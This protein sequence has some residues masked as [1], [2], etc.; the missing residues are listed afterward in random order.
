MQAVYRPTLW[1]K[2]ASYAIGGGVIALALL[3]AV[4]GLNLSD[5][6]QLVERFF[7]WGFALLYSLFIVGTGIALSHLKPNKHCNFWNEFGHQMGNSIATLAL[8]FTLLGISLGVGGL[9]E[10]PLSPENAPDIIAN[11]TGQFSLAFLTTVVGLPT[12]TA[13]RAVVSLR[14]QHIQEKM[15]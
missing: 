12:A 15:A 7:G 13:I 11:L 3:Q 6:T 10:T 9:A 2:G 14:Y 8:T 1:I 4:L 5:V